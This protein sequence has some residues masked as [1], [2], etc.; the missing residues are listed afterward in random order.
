MAWITGYNG[1]EATRDTW[2]RTVFID[3]RLQP[4]DQIRFVSLN[5]QPPECTLLLQLSQLNNNKNN[6]K[7]KHTAMKPITWFPYEY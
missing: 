1:S 5:V 3:V 2:L 4:C 6:N 7:I